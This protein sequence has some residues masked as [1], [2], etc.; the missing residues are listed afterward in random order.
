V[1]ERLTMKKSIKKYFTKIKYLF[2]RV[3]V[4]D[5]EGKKFRLDEAIYEVIH[6]II[7]QSASGGKILFIGNGASASNF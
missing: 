3:I 7:K 6:L 2:N 1:I 4:T 5:G